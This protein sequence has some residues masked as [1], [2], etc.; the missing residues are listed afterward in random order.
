M[1]FRTRLLLVITLS[2]MLAVSAF[3]DPICGPCTFLYTPSPTALGSDE[4]FTTQCVVTSH[5][6]GACVWDG[7]KC[8]PSQQ[9]QVSFSVTLIPKAGS[10]SYCNISNYSGTLTDVPVSGAVRLI[11]SGG[12]VANRADSHNVSISCGAHYEYAIAKQGLSS[13]FF[14]AEFEC[15]SCGLVDPP[16]G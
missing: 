8:A 9:C 11:W 7:S 4:C 3:A 16:P 10:P 13:D 12:Y 2:Y 6:N 15:A 5:S 1:S 14:Y